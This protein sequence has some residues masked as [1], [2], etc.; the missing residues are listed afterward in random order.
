MFDVHLS[1]PS[2]M[3]IGERRS[4]PHGIIHPHI[5]KMESLRREKEKCED[6]KKTFA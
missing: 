5:Q 1:P 2:M 3:W 4:L 6:A